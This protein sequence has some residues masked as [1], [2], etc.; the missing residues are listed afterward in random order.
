MGLSATQQSFQ[1][2]VTA[3]CTDGNFSHT[4]VTAEQPAGDNAEQ[5]DS[6]GIVNTNK[7]HSASDATSCLLQL[8]ADTIR[9]DVD[10]DNRQHHSS[11]TLPSVEVQSVPNVHRDSDNEELMLVISDAAEVVDSVSHTVNTSR[12]PRT[13]AVK[14][15]HT[16]HEDVEKEENNGISEHCCRMFSNDDLSVFFAS[17]VSVS[18]L[19][20]KLKA[21][22]KRKAL[23]KCKHD[24]TSE[25]DD[26]PA[27]DEHE[28]NSTVNGIESAQQCVLPSHDALTTNF[29]KSGVSTDEC[30]VADI[31]QSGSIQVSLPATHVSQC[32]L[33]YSLANMSDDAACGFL[34]SS[35]CLPSSSTSL[36]IPSRDQ[37]SSYLSLMSS[38]RDPTLLAIGSSVSVLDRWSD[39]DVST[40]LSKSSAMQVKS[41]GDNSEKPLQKLLKHNCANKQRFLYP[42]AAHVYQSPVS[43]GFEHTSNDQ[44]FFSAKRLKSLL[45][46]TP[47]VLQSGC[48]MVHST[49]E[50]HM[51]KAA[52]TGI[53]DSEC[54]SNVQQ[55]RVEDCDDSA[56]LVLT[57]QS[58][59]VTC[60]W[61]RITVTSCMNAVCDIREVNSY[62][63]CDGSSIAG[64]AVRETYCYTAQKMQSQEISQPAESVSAYVPSLTDDVCCS[65]L[66]CDFAGQTSPRISSR[67]TLCDVGVQTTLASEHTCNVR[68]QSS[69]VDAAVQTVSLYCTC[70]RISQLCK[71]RQSACSSQEANSQT[72]NE[73]RQDHDLQG[74]GHVTNVS[75]MSCKLLVPNMDIL[76]VSN[77]DTCENFSQFHGCA[78]QS[79]GTVDESAVK[80]HSTTS[81]VSGVRS[82]TVNTSN[83]L[84]AADSTTCTSSTAASG[85]RC[86]VTANHVASPADEVVDGVFKVPQC[87]VSSETGRPHLDS[88]KTVT[89]STSDCFRKAFSTGFISAGG[90]PLNVKLSSKLNARKLFENLGCT[91]GDT[92]KNSTDTCHFSNTDFLASSRYNTK[93]I[94]EDSTRMDTGLF[95]FTTSGLMVSENDIDPSYCRSDGAVNCSNQHEEMYNHFVCVSSLNMTYE[96]SESSCDLSDIHGKSSASLCKF[97]AANTN[98]VNPCVA[99]HQPSASSSI[100]C[101]T[102]RVANMLTT[103]KHFTSHQCTGNAHTDVSADHSVFKCSGMMQKSH[104][105]DMVSNGF[106]PFK[107]PRTSMQFSKRGKNK[108]PTEVDD[109]HLTH[110]TT[111]Q[112]HSL[113]LVDK[114]NSV[115]DTELLCSLTNTQCVEAL[116][117]LLVMVNTAESLAM[118]CSDDTNGLVS[119]ELVSHISAAVNLSDASGTNNYASNSNVSSNSDNVARHCSAVCIMLASNTEQT[120]ENLLSG[121]LR[122]T[123]DDADTDSSNLSMNKLQSVTFPPVISSDSEMCIE[124]SVLIDTIEQNSAFCFVTDAGVQEGDSRDV[125]G[126]CNMSTVSLATTFTETKSVCNVHSSQSNYDNE[127]GADTVACCNWTNNSASW[128][129]E[130]E[131]QKASQSCEQI[132]ADSVDKSESEHPFDGHAFVRDKCCFQ[133]NN[134]IEIDINNRAVQVSKDN[135]T[136][137]SSPFVFF[138]A[139]GSQI[140]VS[141]ETLRSVRCKWNNH[142]TGAN[143]ISEESRTVT[144]VSVVSKQFMQ[145]NAEKIHHPSNVASDSFS[146][147]T[148]GVVV[149]ELLTSGNGSRTMSANDTDEYTLLP[150]SAVGRHTADMQST[151]LI[152]NKV[153]EPNVQTVHDNDDVSSDHV[154]LSADTSYTSC[155]TTS[156]H[157]GCAQAAEHRQPFRAG[158]DAEGYRNKHLTD[159][160]VLVPLYSVPES[161]C[162]FLCMEPRSRHPGI[163]FNSTFARTVIPQKFLKMY[164]HI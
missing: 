44:S 5:I 24:V 70:N 51:R 140:N 66:M 76:S 142:F 107:A 148:G 122:H 115:D 71:S 54:S 160:S 98:V 80:G 129:C 58:G 164:V 39:N 2:P 138:S 81:L 31:S 126:C 162:F 22:P 110:S 86:T 139:K 101:F 6:E 83:E 18:S 84:V 102:D 61:N 45:Y 125:G 36:V 69:F 100:Q 49:A 1:E 159:R 20:A 132:S 156:L 103:T 97:K 56:Q 104:S 37:S 135:M 59:V 91:E 26:S 134:G 16:W 89:D 127:T 30:S 133:N 119:Q 93:K 111:A 21:I 106:K 23:S 92:V 149:D 11:K 147:R 130:T 161:K 151:S 3:L 90:K 145:T 4:R 75:D 124:K 155:L 10:E 60:G 65:K 150:V 112:S 28:P 118:P 8:T 9:D 55:L 43:N 121:Q 40:L 146:S 38:A 68:K 82:K 87:V 12:T 152:D 120:C 74:T 25:C 67:T 131:N 137:K 108:F 99:P 64:P 33:I 35:A 116:D 72:T 144:E 13:N 63:A 52:S 163:F 136:H 14:L 78:F 15:R 47:A 113:N 79:A 88:L 77:A 19:S 114:P 95:P 34:Q 73:L 143:S 57:S 94:E 7:H 17:P 50:E 41:Y 158:N 29:D 62:A 32:H 109:E 141:D 46:L 27:C 123:L 154:A 117:N 53:V 48:M 85:N 153:C 42:S 157:I 105:S 128:R 96:S